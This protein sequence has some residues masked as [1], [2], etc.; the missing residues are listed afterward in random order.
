[1]YPSCSKAV[2][3]SGTTMAIIRLLC[4]GIGSIVGVVTDKKYVPC[5]AVSN[6]LKVLQKV[7]SGK[8]SLND[9]V[10]RFS[11]AIQ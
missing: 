7:I 11:N 8:A 4:H 2:K 1:M 9:L 3:D 6:W 10:E 5:V